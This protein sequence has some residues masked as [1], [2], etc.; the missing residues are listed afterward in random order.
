MAAPNRHAWPLAFIALIASLPSA[1][2]QRFVTA[3]SVPAQ[4][5]ADAKFAAQIRPQIL[6]QTQPAGG[7]YVIGKQVIEQLVER[8]PGSAA[9]FSWN[10]RIAPNIGNVFSSPDGTI[11]VDEDLAQRMGARAGLWAAALSHEIA[12]VIHRDWARRFLLEKS[13][14]EGGAAQISLGGGDSLSGSWL[15]ARSSTMQLA[16]FSQAMEF[17]ADAEGLMLMARAGFHPDFVPALHHLV[18]A[19]SEQ[20]ERK[21]ADTTHPGWD[22]RSEHLQ[23]LYAAAGKEFDRLWPARYESPGG[24]PPIVVYAGSPSVKQ[25]SGGDFELLVPLHCQNLSGAV[26]VVLRVKANGSPEMHQLTGCTSNRTLITFVLADG[27]LLRKRPR[28]QGE[29]SVLDDRGGLLLRSLAPVR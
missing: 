14:R 8:L 25:N 22:E 11:V 28:T 16:A 27:E 20:L 13:L 18:Q 1:T 17:E 5:T 6:S 3:E 4:F 15:D 7:R 19:Q 9:K 12:H 10:L 23:K 2:A 21:I 24:E 29:I 26:E